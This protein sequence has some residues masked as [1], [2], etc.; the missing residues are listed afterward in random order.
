MSV[1]QNG[2]CIQGIEELSDE[3]MRYVLMKVLLKT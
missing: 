3:H 2:L 1:L